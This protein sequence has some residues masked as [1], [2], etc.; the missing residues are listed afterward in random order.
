M[1][2]ADCYCIAEEAQAELDSIEG[3]L[4]LLELQI[5]EL[6]EKQASLT[7]RKNKLRKILGS[8]SDSAQ[9]SGSAKASKPALSKKDLQHYE[10]SGERNSTWNAS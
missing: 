7:S 10:E 5:S 6:L 3:E 4:E 9:A 1:K 8:S 2:Q